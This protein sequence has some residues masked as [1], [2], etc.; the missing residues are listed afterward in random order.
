VAFL[1]VV[2]LFGVAAFPHHRPIWLLPTLIVVLLVPT[3]W[4]IAREGAPSIVLS[5]F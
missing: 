2:H 5:E 1:A 4:L 3:S